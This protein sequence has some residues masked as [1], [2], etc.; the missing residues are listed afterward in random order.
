MC[1]PLIYMALKI[2]SKMLTCCIPYMASNGIVKVIKTGTIILLLFMQGS[3]SCLE[4][5]LVSFLF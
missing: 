4:L 1:T 2:L 5:Y 3:R